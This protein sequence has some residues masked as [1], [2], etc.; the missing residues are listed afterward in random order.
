MWQKI[1]ETAQDYSN[2]IQSIRTI[3]EV[4]AVLAV[5]WITIREWFKGVDSLQIILIIVVMCCLLVIIFTYY[6]DWKRKN[7]IK[8][9]PTL[10]NKLDAIIRTD[11]EATP[12][13]IDVR[14]YDKVFSDFCELCDVNVSEAIDAIGSMDKVKISAFA[15]K[16]IPVIT[17][18]LNPQTKDD[19][20]KFLILVEGILNEN[21]LGI[22]NTQNKAEYQ[23]AYNGF[24]SIEK[25][26]ENIDIQRKITNYFL[27]SQAL[28]SLL[29]LFSYL[30][31]DSFDKDLLPAKG[32]AATNIM[33]SLIY[34]Q[35][36]ILLTEIRDS[37]AVKNK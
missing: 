5:L 14:S 28:Y 6:I 13:L 22:S 30:H 23:D 11:I 16:T 7:N 4:I 17:G 9:I 1:K 12:N 31:T 19:S 15:E 26:I 29:F 34:M 36:D 35:V 10:L 2:T 3:A 32:R 21:K 24:K 25:Q 37:I 20:L 18:I 27:W 8:L 33:H